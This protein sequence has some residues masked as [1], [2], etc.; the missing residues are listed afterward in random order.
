MGEA[1]P[2]VRR[3]LADRTPEQAAAEL[4]RGCR[5]ADVNVRKH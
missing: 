5:L 1:D 4:V 2:T 3:M